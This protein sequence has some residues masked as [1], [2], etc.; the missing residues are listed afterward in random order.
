MGWS[1]KNGVWQLHR[2]PGCLSYYDADNVRKYDA[3]RID[4]LWDLGPSGDAN[5]H[6]KQDIVANM[7]TIVE[8]DSDFNG[9]NSLVSGSGIWLYTGNFSASMAQP[10]T[11]YVV[12]K[13][14]ASA[15][16]EC[17]VDGLSTTAREAMFSHQNGTPMI[18][19]GATLS[20]GISYKSQKIVHCGVFDSA[21]SSQYTNSVTTPSSTGNA[22]AGVSAGITLLN[23]S[24]RTYPV[25]G[26]FAAAAIYKGIHDASTRSRVMRYLGDKY[27]IAIT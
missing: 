15:V 17:F 8:A 6:A 16:Y 14:G 23:D 5:R 21:S 12:G 2:E 22:G 11:I 10:V 24:S 4:R 13:P 19:A 26:K 27:G 1:K 9:H 3:S 18:S 20:G 7:P 25:L